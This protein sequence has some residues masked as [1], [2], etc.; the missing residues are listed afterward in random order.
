MKLLSCFILIFLLSCQS[1][2]DNM[3][4]EFGQTNS[5]ASLDG[6][7]TL[8]SK[9]SEP[10]YTKSTPPSAAIPSA[11]VI[12]ARKQVPILCYHQIRDWKPTDSKTSR[13]YIVPPAVFAAQMRMLAD[14]GFHTI[15]ADQ[16][17]CLPDI[18]PA[19]ARKAHS[20][21]F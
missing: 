16:L 8:P 6:E 14:S 3:P 1:L 7:T 9:S 20:A 5:M 12:L 10:V 11:S 21:E 13:T 18:R 2:P 17:I 19:F 15:S 4:S